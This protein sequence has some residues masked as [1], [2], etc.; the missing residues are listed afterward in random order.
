[1]PMLHAIT[2]REPL[3]ACIAT[4]DP[5]ASMTHDALLSRVVFT[6]REPALQPY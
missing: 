5:R 2:F 4:T 3:L 6:L 1:M